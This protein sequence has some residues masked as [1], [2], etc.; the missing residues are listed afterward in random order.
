MVSFLFFNKNHRHFNYKNN[1]VFPTGGKKKIIKVVLTVKPIP[2]TL[3]SVIS[4][5]FFLPNVSNS[6]GAAKDAS[7]DTPVVKRW[8]LHGLARC[9]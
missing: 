5:F 4:S 8:I 6:M 9:S 7:V 2:L 1:L 3:T